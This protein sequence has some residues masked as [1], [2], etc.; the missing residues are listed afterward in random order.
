LNL[1]E[2]ELPDLILMDLSLPGMDGLTATRIIREIMEGML[3]PWG[4]EVYQ[5]E[6]GTEALRIVGQVA[7]DV[8]LLDIM[9]PGLDGFEVA[10]RLKAGE[11]TQSS[12]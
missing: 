8:I 3:L 1:V 6:D 12:G 5:A 11:A 2:K 4:Y 7:P 10:R 9:M